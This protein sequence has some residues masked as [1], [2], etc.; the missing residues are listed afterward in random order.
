[1]KQGEKEIKIYFFGSKK[2]FY[3]PGNLRKVLHDDDPVL[4]DDHRVAHE[5]D[6]VLNDGDPL[7]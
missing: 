1:M 4:H 7:S 2:H 3:Q 5:G 6:R